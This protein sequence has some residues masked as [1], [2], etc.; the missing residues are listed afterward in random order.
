MWLAAPIKKSMGIENTT[1]V[2]EARNA[3]RP[4]A[5]A[6]GFAWPPVAAATA[7]GMTIFW[8]GQITRHTLKSISVP[9]SAPVRIATAHGLDHGAVPAG[10][11]PM[12]LAMI[13]APERKVTS[14]LQRNHHRARG[15]SFWVAWLFVAA[16][17][18]A[19]N[20]PWTK[21]K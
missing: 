11:S 18:S 2:R 7:D 3:R 13:S 15:T 17:A 16:S 20:G 9:N 14:A 4:A 10:A 8:L 1:L 6:T 21:L 12:R 19:K 5:A